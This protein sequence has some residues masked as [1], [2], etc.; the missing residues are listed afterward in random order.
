L[1][2]GKNNLMFK[3]VDKSEKS[4][5]LGMDLIQIICVRE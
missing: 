3:L 5:G 2:E 1:D 4:T